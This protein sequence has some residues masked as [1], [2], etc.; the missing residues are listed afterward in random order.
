[1]SEGPNVVVRVTADT[2]Q[3]SQQISQVGTNWD[4]VGMQG[5][6]AAKDLTNGIGGLLSAE[7]G[8]FNAQMRVNV[9]QIE[10]T[11][12]VRQY[13]AGSIQAQR[14]LIGLKEAQ[15]SVA[16]AQ[17][18]LNLRFIQFALTTGPQI[19]TAISKMIA[20]VMGMTLANY[21]ETASWYAKAAAIGI[22]V[23]LLTAGLAVFGGLLA[24]A[25]ITSTLG[26]QQQMNTI[27]QNNVFQNNAGNTQAA[28]TAANSQLINGVASAVRP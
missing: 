16:I 19:Y 18:Q 7:Q 20:Q 11:L 27:N 21:Q 8:I 5:V 9:A 14:A 4:Q 10:Y 22:T 17:D 28:V 24:G 25:G 12:T 13:G 3:A 23:G 15:E 26:Q 1:M 6:K 2:T